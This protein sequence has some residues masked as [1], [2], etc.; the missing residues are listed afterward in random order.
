MEL[1]NL[2]SLKAKSLWLKVYA[3]FE[4]VFAFY[5]HRY[6]LFI[7]V[8]VRNLF[9][10]YLLSKHPSISVTHHHIILII[11]RRWPTPCYVVF[12]SDDK[13]KI[14]VYVNDQQFRSHTLAKYYSPKEKKYCV[15]GFSNFLKNVLFFVNF[16]THKIILSQS[17]YQIFIN[18][19][20]TFAHFCSSA[21]LIFFLIFDF[22][23][24][25]PF[26]RFPLLQSP[27]SSPL[28][29]PKNGGRRRDIAILGV[30]WIFSIED[31]KFK[32][33]RKGRR[34]WHVWTFSTR[35]SKIITSL[36]HVS[37]FRCLCLRRS[38]FW[39]HIS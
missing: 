29:P 17:V 35:A 20:S 6:F 27:L 5:K 21:I 33:K 26:P 10:V 38:Y 18:L 28:N 12:N 9:V 22:R 2:T 25:S 37:F 3:N 7:F 15:N 11:I 14:H 1:R 39:S 19:V 8:F 16:T 4:I 23:L 24:F 32:K 34:N 13:K 36:L 31:I 30:A